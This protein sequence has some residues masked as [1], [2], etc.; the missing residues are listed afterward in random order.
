MEIDL[1]IDSGSSRSHAAFSASA[2]KQRNFS[3]MPRTSTD[4][5][6]PSSA[7][8]WRRESSRSALSEVRA[9][10]PSSESRS[11]DSRSETL[12]ESSEMRPLSRETVFSLSSDTKAREASSSDTLDLSASFSA[13]TFPPEP[14][15]TN[16]DRPAM[17][18]NPG[19]RISMPSGR[20]QRLQ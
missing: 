4:L 7:R 15:E 19:E 8:T 5:I 3:M 14:S 2:A 10:A 11:L 1:R 18:P 17:S 16:L 9:L 12:R 6:L 13:R 20:P